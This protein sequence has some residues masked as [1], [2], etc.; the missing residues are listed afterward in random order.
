MVN[1]DSHPESKGKVEIKAG[2]FVEEIRGNCMNGM[3]GVWE[4]WEY[5]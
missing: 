5:L 3:F 4:S 2:K 1:E